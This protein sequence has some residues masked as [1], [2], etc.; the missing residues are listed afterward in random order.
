MSRYLRSAVERTLAKGKMAFV[1]GARQVG[2][3]TLALEE[4]A[5]R[6]GTSRNV[7]GFRASTRCT[8]R[9]ER[10]FATGKV[11]VLPFGSF[12]SELQMP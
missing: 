7:P 8:D 6:S 3:T 12:C 9:A 2:K 5:P 4:S 10:H 1:G 11:T